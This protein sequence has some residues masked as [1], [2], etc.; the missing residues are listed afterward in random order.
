MI[1]TLSESDV[2][3]VIIDKLTDLGYEF[4]N[5]EENDENSWVCARSLDEFID[6]S[7]LRTQLQKINKGVKVGLIDDAISSILR[8]TNPSLFVEFFMII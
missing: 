3:N 8:I 2:E 6:V 4:L 7:L 1:R 5:P